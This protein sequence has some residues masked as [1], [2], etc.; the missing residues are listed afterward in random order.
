MFLR[1]ISKA[2][3]NSDSILHTPSTGLAKSTSKELMAGNSIEIRKDQKIIFEKYQAVLNKNNG[4]QREERI[5][6]SVTSWQPPDQFLSLLQS[7]LQWL[8]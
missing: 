5:L 6:K 1:L 7:A 8:R 2:N 4:P 3:Q